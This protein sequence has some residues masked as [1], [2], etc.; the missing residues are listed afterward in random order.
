MKYDKGVPADIAERARDFA[1]NAHTRIGH[2]RKYHKLPYA[3][4]LHNVAVL[5]GSVT[6]DPETLAAAWL[7]DVVEDTPATLEDVEKAFGTSVASLVESLTDVSRPRDGNR[8]ARKEIDRQHLAKA[9]R[10]AKTVKLADLIDNCRDIC[11]H[12]ER[13]A[14]VYLKEMA[15]LLEVLQE[16]DAGLYRQAIEAHHDCSRRLGVQ[17]VRDEMP[18]IPRPGVWNSEI[19]PA[20]VIRHYAESFTALD[21][22]DPLRSF[23]AEKNSEDVLQIM[24]ENSLDVVFL[25]DEGLI[26][27]YV[28][29]AD[30]TG[31][32]CSEHLR[33]F[34]AGQV[35]RGDD[36][37]TEVIRI[38]TL[39]EYAFVSL[40]DEVVGGIN[41]SCLNK[42]VAR[43]WLFGI[44]TLTELELVRLISEH[45]PDGTWKGHVSRGRMERAIAL[46]HERQRR[47]QQSSLVDCLQ[48]SDKAQILMKKSAVRDLFGFTSK[49][50]AVE[51]IKQLESLRNNLAHAQDIVTHDWAAI[52]RIASRLEDA[53]LLRR[54]HPGGGSTGKT[55]ETLLRGK[56]R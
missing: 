13:F 43:M 45:F 25:R 2:L 56:R 22:A 54:S 38:L 44:I 47:N 15:K 51:A 18:E 8:S 53:V 27:G 14:R 35:I 19:I 42:P 7:H 9:G 1:V 12:D 16:G 6:N 46:H 28:R 49:N 31:G 40:L 26:R 20:H 11:R 36:P 21:V 41:R 52:A 3:T 37:L 39:Y 24:N 32:R 34:R 5:V 55:T 10:Q 30:L 29:R 48:F 50:A 33:P 4:H 23:D 17:P